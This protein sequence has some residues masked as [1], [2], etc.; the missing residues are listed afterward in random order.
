MDRSLSIPRPLAEHVSALVVP[1]IAGAILGLA[2]ACVVAPIRWDDQSFYTYVA[3]HLLD[4][5]RLYSPD[6]QDTNPPLIAWI[7]VV[8]ALLARATGATPH[9]SFVAFVAALAAGVIAWSLRLI[10]SDRRTPRRTWLAIVLVYATVILPSVAWKLREVAAL[11]MGLRYD[12]GQREHF[13]ALLVLPYLFASARRLAREPLPTFEAVA[14]GAVAALSF[15]L[16]PQYLTVVG[17]VEAVMVAYS[18][19]LRPLLRPELVALILT[20]LAYCAAVWLVTPDYFATIPMVAAVYGDFGRQ[21]PWQIM[22]LSKY[23]FVVVAAALLGLVLLR[24]AGPMQRMAAVFLAAGIAALAAFFLQSKGWTDHLLPAETF[25]VVALG[26]AVIGRGTRLVSNRRPAFD[27]VT[28][29]VAAASCLAALAIYYPARAAL[30]ANS[31]WA[32]Y[33]AE[34]NSATAAYLPGTGL[35]ILGDGIFSQFDIAMDR[36]FVWASRWPFMI[37]P[38][39]TIRAERGG[40]GHSDYLMVSNMLAASGRGIPDARQ[41]SAML[42]RN[43]VEDFERWKPAIVLVQRCDDPVME[44]CLFGA[45]FRVD[46]WL[47]EEPAFAAIWSRYAFDRHI[48]RFDLYLLRESGQSQ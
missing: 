27:F 2:L 48:W 34:T 30:W 13:L 33:I 16:K 25:I 38:E 21:T 10:P 46:D 18:R 17:A 37:L 40:A 41:Y 4:G 14:I 9:A 45:G 20:G 1:I 43:A 29:A 26:L 39:A 6:I 36:G 35:L 5:Y 3:P 8:P 15:C 32:H 24:G 47:A 42:R 19:S 22:L 11:G 28:V 7:N 23:N 44:P 12:F 31:A